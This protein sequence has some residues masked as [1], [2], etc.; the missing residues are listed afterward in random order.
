MS[1]CQSIGSFTTTRNSFRTNAKMIAFLSCD[2]I[3]PPG[4]AKQVFFTCKHLFV[5]GRSLKRDGLQA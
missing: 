2:M 1:P 4:A 5:M 3:I